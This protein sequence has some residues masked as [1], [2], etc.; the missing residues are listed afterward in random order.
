MDLIYYVLGVLLL[1]LIAIIIGTFWHHLSPEKKKS[2]DSDSENCCGKSSSDDVIETQESIQESTQEGIQE[3]TT[4]TEQE[5][6]GEENSEQS[7]VMEIEVEIEDFDEVENSGHKEE[8]DESIKVATD[9]VNSDETVESKPTKSKKVPNPKF[10]IYRSK[11][12]DKKYYF[13]LLAKNGKN[14]LKSEGHHTIDDAKH[15]VAKVVENCGSYENYEL[16]DSKD[17]QHYF[18]LSCDTD[19]F[20]GV[21]ETYK[22]KKSAEK[23]IESVRKNGKTDNIEYL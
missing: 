17:N 10:Q 9:C 3:S 2:C 4:V 13:R 12:K 19:G 7:P 21:S 20:L 1:A 11:G 8:H 5:S 15:A 18:T 6:I 16:L 23:G 22:V 14:I